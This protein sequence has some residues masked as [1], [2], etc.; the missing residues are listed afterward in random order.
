MRMLGMLPLVLYCGLALLLGAR[1]AQ[2]QSQAKPN[3]IVIMTDDQVSTDAAIL[4]QRMHASSAPSTWLR[5]HMAVVF[6][7]ARS[8]WVAYTIPQ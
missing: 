3:F 1:P 5:A 2:S 8:V 7:A 4:R 6:Q